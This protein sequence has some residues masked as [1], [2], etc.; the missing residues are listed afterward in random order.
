MRRVASAPSDPDSQVLAAFTDRS[1]V[2]TDT[3]FLVAL[4]AAPVPPTR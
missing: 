1:P 4:T 2:S 3:P